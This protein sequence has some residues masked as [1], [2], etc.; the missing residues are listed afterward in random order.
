MANIIV[1]DFYHVDIKT[2]LHDMT[3]AQVESI[4]VDY[5]YI[6]LSNIADTVNSENYTIEESHSYNY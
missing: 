1:P 2:F 5:P 6:Y 4:L 3:P